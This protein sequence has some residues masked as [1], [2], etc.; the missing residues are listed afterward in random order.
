MLLS[1]TLGWWAAE[2]KC[3]CSFPLKTWR[4]LSRK[5]KQ[6]LEKRKK[7]NEIC[8]GSWNIRARTLVEPA[9]YLSDSFPMHKNIKRKPSQCIEIH[10]Q[11]KKIQTFL[12]PCLYS[13]LILRYNLQLFRISMFWCGTFMYAFAMIMEWNIM[14]LMLLLNRSTAHFKPVIVKKIFICILTK[15]T[16]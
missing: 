1:I 14:L 9:N 11:I 12:C 13:K 8:M 2:E 5:S 4:I 6:V 10:E 3:L 15:N 16:W 7:G